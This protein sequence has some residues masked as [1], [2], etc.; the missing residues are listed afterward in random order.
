MECSIMISISLIVV[1][2][3]KVSESS[4]KYIV[5]LKMIIQHVLKDVQER[6][7]ENY[8]F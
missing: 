1:N 5:S 3:S 7:D 4:A 8:F 2:R 6:L